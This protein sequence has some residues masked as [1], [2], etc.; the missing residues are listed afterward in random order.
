MNFILRQCTA[1]E[2]NHKGKSFK[3]LTNII[4]EGF[5]S[6]GCGWGDKI[7]NPSIFS[8]S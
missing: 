1:L 6:K 4:K 7:P 3:I 2:L 5:K 8:F